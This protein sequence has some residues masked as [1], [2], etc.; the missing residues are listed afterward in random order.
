MNQE[1]IQQI[2]EG[3]KYVIRNEGKTFSPK[4]DTSVLRLDITLDE[5]PPV[6]YKHN[7][8]NKHMESQVIQLHE[9]YINNLIA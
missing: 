8:V 1:V 4:T 2:V 6:E 9:Y 3:E 7:V 5:F